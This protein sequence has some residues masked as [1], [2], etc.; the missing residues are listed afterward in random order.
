MKQKI[1]N[2]YGL[3]DNFRFLV[4]RLKGIPVETNLGRYTPVVDKIRQH[5]FRKL[6][7][8]GLRE[9][10]QE[11][12]KR[13]ASGENPDNLLPVTYA[14][15]GELCA[16]I[17]GQRPYNVQYLAGV[18]LYR[19]RLAQM[20]TGEGKTLAIVFPACLQALQGKKVH[21]MT[22]N[23]YLAGRDTGF[24]GKVF[25]FLGLTTGCVQESTPD[26]EKK[27]AYKADITYLT[28][29]QAGF[30]FLR[31]QLAYNRKDLVQEGLQTAIIDEAD[32]IM[33]DEAR[34][35]MVIAGAMQGSGVDPYAIN[36]IIPFLQPERDFI[37]DKNR[38]KI[39]LTVSG[40][41]MVQKLM[42]CGG[43]HETRSLHYY[44]AVHVALHAHHLLERDRDYIVRRGRIE[45]VDEFTG[46]IADKRR[47]PYGI[48]AALEAKE[49][50]TL[51]PEGRIYGSI[52]IQHFLGLYRKIAGLTATAVQSAAEFHR[53]Y[54]LGTVIIPPN[55]PVRRMDAP[56]RIFKTKMEKMK[57]IM[58]EI[59]K[60]HTTGRPVLVGTV[61]VRESTE[62]AKALT[63]KGIP[64]QVLN[65]RNDNEE[66]AIIAR[67]GMLST[68]TI[69][70]NMAGRGTDIKLGGEKGTGREKILS[71]GGLYVIGTNR[72]ES[73]RIDNQLRGRAGRQGDPGESRFFIS[74]EDPLF[75]RFGLTEFIPEKYLK[76]GFN[77]EIH[78]IKVK[79]EV[80]R[81][82]DIIESQNL[83]IRTTLVK[84]SSLLEKQRQ[85]IQ[86]IRLNAL[87]NGIFPESLVDACRKKYKKL[88][89]VLSKEKAD[90][91]FSR[92][93]LV[94]IDR[95]WSGH[96]ASADDLQEGIHL[97]RYSGDEPLQKF[98]K[99]MASAFESGLDKA[100]LAAC[101]T[102][103]DIRIT[104]TGIDLDDK[105]IS[106]PSS[107]W[108]YLVNDNLPVSFKI[109][110]N[111]FR[112]TG[113]MMMALIFTVLVSPVLAVYYLVKRLQK[114]KRIIGTLKN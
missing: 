114:R 66:A 36:N 28:A 56:D 26:T 106:G 15:V 101:K 75:K 31:D 59:E 80:I 71:L 34:I 107:T 25:G 53:F 89:C 17:L 46:R 109:T 85:C 100:V 38:R 105:A 62:L 14:L 22:A 52:T 24:L 43:I 27:S 94:Y 67:A 83:E 2:T 48:Q 60:S 104:N 19:G 92:I 58:E 102:I 90:T 88:Q 23:D 70:T 97:H 68:V 86:I 13:L 57:A 29:K 50:L 32:F 30:D 1:H 8:S 74:L 55:M 45:L 42:G 112:N 81:A 78:D 82:Q 54:G 4:N 91:L 37:T 3:R 35:P 72:H 96:L 61:S 73:E 65:A 51:R 111:A 108:T 11:I 12:R 79:R 7:H 20:N 76:P 99:E 9:K 64:C 113:Y 84:Y 16:R 103:K 33:I 49:S 77:E 5:S 63:G 41:K 47:W 39:S 10:A 21:V 69:S 110:W 18:V 98:I 44:V 95:F 40:Q 87:I 6:S 93:L